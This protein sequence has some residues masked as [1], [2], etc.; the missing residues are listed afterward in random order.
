MTSAQVGLHEMTTANWRCTRQ[1]DCGPHA[2]ISVHSASA[3]PPPTCPHKGGQLWRTQSHV[4]SGLWSF[5]ATAQHWQSIFQR[6][7]VRVPLVTLAA[8][9]LSA[10]QLIGS[11]LE[12]LSSTFHRN[13]SWASRHLVAHFVHLFAPF[14]PQLP[15]HTLSN[16]TSIQRLQ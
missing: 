11:I 9:M 15:F 1:H 13:K 14:R 7:L 10:G 6:D 3:S 12:A 16:Q 4:A 5:E 8:S 2:T